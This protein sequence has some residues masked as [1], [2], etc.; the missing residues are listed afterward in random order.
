MESGALLFEEETFQIRSAV[1]EVS[2]VLGTGFLE[3]VYQE[4]LAL[5]FGAQGIPFI[6]SPARA[7][8]YED[9]LLSQTYRR[10]FVCFEQIIVE[11]KASREIAPEHRAQT[12]NH[13]KATG[14]RVGLLVN[15]G[16]APK[17]RIERLV[18]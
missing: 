10:D 13:L 1:F 9:R 6:A 16:C 14:L 5:E 11:L 4:A 18:L 8:S 7:I 15:F 2:R 12:L 3:A 17:A